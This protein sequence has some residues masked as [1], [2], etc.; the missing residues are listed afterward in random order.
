MAKEDLNSKDWQSE[1][2]GLEAI[3]RLLTYHQDMIMADIDV[4]VQSL[5][6]ECKNLRSQ[7]T[8]A[9]L[10]TLVILFWM[11]GKRNMVYIQHCPDKKNL[12]YITLI[13][14]LLVV[15]ENIFRSKNKRDKVVGL[16][17]INT[18]Y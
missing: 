5:V 17:Y 1:V 10:Q 12:I 15:D 14:L 13:P 18:T 4:L 2:E 3:V 8:R 6:H 16:R 7:V 9:A 11:L